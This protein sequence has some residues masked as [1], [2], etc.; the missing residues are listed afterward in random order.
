MK[1]IFLSIL[2]Y[3]CGSIFSQDYLRPIKFN[4][5]SPNWQQFI[6]DSTTINDPKKN[7]FEHL[8][9]NFILVEES[10]EIAYFIYWDFSKN[11][12]GAFIQKR[13]LITG[14]TL[15]TSLYNLSNSDRH[16][17]PRSAYLDGNKN[18]VIVNLRNNDPDFS[19][20]VWFKASPAFRIYDK[21]NGDLI[22]YIH[23]NEPITEDNQILFF[24]GLNNMSVV[25][26]NSSMIHMQIKPMSNSNTL[27]YIKKEFNNE[28]F[29]TSIDTSFHQRPFPY[30][31]DNGF[32]ILK[33]NEIFSLSHSHSQSSQQLY[34]SENFNKY[35]CT[36]DIYDQNF[37]LKN[38][39]DLTGV[40]PYNWKINYSGDNGNEYWLLC[41]DSTASDRYTNNSSKALVFVGFD[42]RVKEIIDFK[43]N[44]FERIYAAKMPSEVG[45]L[46]ITQDFIEKRDAATGDF[47]TEIIFWKS[48]GNGNLTKLQSFD[49][50]DD[51]TLSISS[52]SLV[53]KNLILGTYMRKYEKITD[54]FPKYQMKGLLGYNFDMLTS[55][56][57][58]IQNKSLIKIFPNPS[59]TIVNVEGV[60]ED[61]NVN[62]FDNQGRLFKTL[63]SF[64]RQLDISNLP[65]GTYIFDVR[66]KDISERHKIVKVD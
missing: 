3:C 52:V 34:E 2:I 13:N 16:E 61:V 1:F 42:G 20:P 21:N 54:L 9:S 17:Y 14:A 35:N 32:N 28:G 62:I 10:N 55:I 23:A 64:E 46:I 50:R 31:F 4:D 65:V 43:D 57:E 18:L 47:V 24:T 6:I 7:G 53:G 39:T 29:F 15:W 30:Y 12:Q 49:Y 41:G 59:T 33:N 19:T 60:S 27:L 48:D 8:T 36:T 51:R 44:K 63:K 26:S 37:L 22:Q 5:F 45:A 66:N 11:Y 38:S 56:N 25:S 40:F 58:T